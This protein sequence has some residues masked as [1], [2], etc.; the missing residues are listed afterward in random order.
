MSAGGFGSVLMA[1]VLAIGFG[2][3]LMR[4]ARQKR[5]TF[6]IHAAVFLK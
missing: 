6:V 3:R 2:Q 1:R 5:S 4:R